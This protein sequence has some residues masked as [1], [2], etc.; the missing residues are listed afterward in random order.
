MIES[1]KDSVLQEDL[2]YIANSN[3][4]LEELSGKTIFITGATG[5]I[6]SQ[7]VKALVCCNRIKKANITIVCLVRSREKVES[8]F[9]ELANDP[10][11][12]FVYGDVTEKIEVDMDK[13]LITNKNGEKALRRKKGTYITID[14]K[15]INNISVEKE[16]ELIKIF[17]YLSKR[18]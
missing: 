2:E 1:P 11:M 15:K 5:L 12:K 8:V 9:G 18:L 3:I 4:P 13:G 10:M 6:G 16:R 7:V 14:A 17:N